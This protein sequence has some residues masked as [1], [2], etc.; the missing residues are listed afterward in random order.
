MA[1]LQIQSRES[2]NS[3]EARRLRTKGI[4]PMA[5]I[6]KGQGTKLVQAQQKDVRSALRRIGGAAVFSVA[7]DSEPKERKVIIKDV[8]RDVIS[9]GI[10]HLTLQ[11]VRDDEVIRISV[12]IKFHGEPDCVTKKKSSLMTPLVALEIHAKPADIPDHFHIDVS[13]MEEVDKILV[14]DIP[15]PA[16]VTTHVPADTVVVTTFHMRAVS[17]EVPSAAETV[18]PAEGEAAPAEGAAAPAAKEGEAKKEG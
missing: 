12:P 3:A 5:L 2:A 13:E 9:R 1:T 17:L 6:L 14:S 10:T 4:L 8:Q 18:V 11:E 15:L 16:G 7:V